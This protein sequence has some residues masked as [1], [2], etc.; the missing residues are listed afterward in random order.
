MDSTQQSIE[1]QQDSVD[2]GKSK[3]PGESTPKSS[4]VRELLNNCENQEETFELIG[5]FPPSQQ[6]KKR[7]CVVSM[8]RGAEKVS[9]FETIKGPHD[10][11]FVSFNDIPQDFNSKYEK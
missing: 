9:I 1:Q 4:A 5:M 11:R 7:P 2:S 10:M 8:D 3:E 6:T